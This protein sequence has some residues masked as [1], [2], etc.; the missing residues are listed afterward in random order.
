MTLK[1][2]RI[3]SI[4]FLVVAA[5]FLIFVTDIKMPSNL[6]EPGPRIMPYLSILLMVICSLGVLVESFTKQQEE[7]PFLSKEGW[8]RL[9]TILGVLVIYSIGLMSIGFLA[10][11]PF[12]AFIVI[13]MLS[14]E[15]K[16]SLIT[17]I[18]GAIIVTAAIYLLFAVGFDVMLPPGMLFD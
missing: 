10:A 9:G 3:I 14:G 8:K 11:T 15:T 4:F 13:N 5:V 2:D 18:I 12:M 17:G 1:K 6:T 16:V 7:K